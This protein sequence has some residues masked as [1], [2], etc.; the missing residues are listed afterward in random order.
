M[1]TGEIEKPHDKNTWERLRTYAEKEPSWI[2]V[3]MY[4][5]FSNEEINKFLDYCEQVDNETNEK[6]GGK[7]V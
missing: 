4:M 3:A 7:M 1:S 5:H 2:I 6:V